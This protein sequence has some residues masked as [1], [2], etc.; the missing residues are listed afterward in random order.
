MVPVVSPILADL[1]LQLL[2]AIILKKIKYNV[3]CY[4]RFVDDCFAIVAE[5][6]KKSFENMFNR[7]LDN[8]HLQFIL[9]EEKGESM[10][11]DWYHRDTW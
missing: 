2:E 5:N 3:P 4:F 9:E 8:E 7:H 10:L 1:V 11:T 6:E